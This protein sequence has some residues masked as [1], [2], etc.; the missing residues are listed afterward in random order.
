MVGFGG[1]G[2]KE[3]LYFCFLVAVT[4]LDPDADAVSGAPCGGHGVI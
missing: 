1:G 4:E 3:N 2:Q